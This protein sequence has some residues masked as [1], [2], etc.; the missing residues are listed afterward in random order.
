[1]KLFLNN[2]IHEKAL[3]LDLYPQQIYQTLLLRLREKC[4]LQPYHIPSKRKIYGIIREL[5][6]SM[7]AN[8]GIVTI[9]ETSTEWKPVFQTLW[10]G[11]FDGEFHQML[12]WSTNEA[13]LY[14]S[15][16]AVSIHTM[17][18]YHGVVYRNH[19]IHS[20]CLCF[21]DV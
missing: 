6:E 3:C 2:F 10:S 20:M 18:D 9:F 4:S 21:S 12:L 14:I 15:M 17:F 8:S 5:Q 7:S 11:D 1:S 13:L 16:C 19:N